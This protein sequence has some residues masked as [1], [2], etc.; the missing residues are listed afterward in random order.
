MIEFLISLKLDIMLLNMPLL[1][2]D[3]VVDTAVVA[4]TAAVETVFDGD[5][6]FAGVFLRA[7]GDL[8]AGFFERATGEWSLYESAAAFRKFLLIRN[9]EMRARERILMRLRA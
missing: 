4:T 2:G 7:V 1:A 9:V 5:F 6:I 8:E 3:F